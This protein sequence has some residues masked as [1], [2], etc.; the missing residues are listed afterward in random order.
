MNISRDDLELTLK[1]WEGQLLQFKIQ[2]DTAQIVC[3]GLALKIAKMPK[4]EKKEVDTTAGQDH[5]HVG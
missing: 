3:E 5:L 4:K 2:L 1:E